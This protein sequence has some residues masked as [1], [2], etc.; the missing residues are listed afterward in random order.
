MKLGLAIATLGVAACGSV[1]QTAPDAAVDETV[2]ASPDAP[3]D[4]TPD[5]RTDCP[6]G[7]TTLCDGDNLVT[8]DEAG[9]ITDTSPCALGCNASAGRC[10]VVDPSN[11]LASHLDEAAA[12]PDLTLSG[13]TTI[14]TTNQTII[15]ATGARVVPTTTLTTGLPV[16][17]F[18]VKVKSF[19][20]NGNVTITGSRALAIVSDGPVLIRN[21][22][23]LS[24]NGSTNGP[25]ALTED[26]TCRGGSAP[27]G[28]VEGKAGGGGGGFGTAGGRGGN[29]GNPLINGAAGGAV[30]PT[31]DLVPLRGGCPGGRASNAS[32]NYAPGGGGGALQLSSNTS[33]TLD[34]GAILAINGGGAKGPTGPVACISGAPCGNGEGGGSGGGLLLE[35]PAITVNASARIYANGGGGTCDVDGSAQNGL[36]SP[37]QPASGQSCSGQTGDGG[38]GAVGALA[39]QNGEDESGDNS[40]G[41][42]GGGGLGR[43]RVNLPVGATFSATISGVQSV[44]V[45]STR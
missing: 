45:L 24:A 44:G 23:T 9:N 1:N 10:K 38:D 35:A 17:V 4:A 18:V 33:I 42:G 29:G 11:G 31:S 25:G 8:C 36:L 3:P 7:T 39:A 27:A 15:D 34:S 14:D 16:E 32:A 21:L 28:N 20:T 26:A 5:A 13:A 19:T 43:V 6:I 22:V 30:S 37:T 2:D 40:V 41:G 12:A